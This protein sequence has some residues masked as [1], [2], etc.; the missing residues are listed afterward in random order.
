MSVAAANVQ[1]RF[2]A[3]HGLDPI[4]RTV[5]GS[6]CN[7]SIDVSTLAGR[8]AAYSLLRTRG[9]IRVAMQS[10]S[11]RTTKWLA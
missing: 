6:N 8:T 5:D 3:T 11:A 4:S 1:Q 7:H 10:P 9:L 2:V